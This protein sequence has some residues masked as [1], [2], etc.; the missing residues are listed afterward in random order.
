M[1]KTKTKFNL[2]K[3]LHSL[4]PKRENRGT[5]LV[6]VMALL[7]ALALMGFFF[8]SLAMNNRNDAF[9]FRDASID[10]SDAIEEDVEFIFDTTLR[11]LILGARENE[12][13]SV[14]YGGRNSLV[15]TMLGR[16]MQPFS[17]K[18]INVTWRD[19]SLA[20]VVPVG[21]P[22]VDMLF[23]GFNDADSDLIDDERDAD[24]GNNPEYLQYLQINKSVSAQ[25][26][27]FI[28]SSGA[29][30]RAT[31]PAV[32]SDYDFV[33]A[34]DPDTDITYPDIN[35]IFLAY[36]GIA[37]DG[38][39]VII[40]SFHRPQ[41]N[42][43]FITINDYTDTTTEQYVLRP[44][45]EH[46][47]VASDGTITTTRRFIYDVADATD[48]AVDSGGASGSVATVASGAFP[49][50][51]T[52]VSTV[53]EGVWKNPA[54]DTYLTSAYEY[55]VD[56]D[57]DGVKESIYL[58]LHFPLL[59][60]SN[61]QTYVPMVAMKVVELNSL[62]DLNTHGNHNGDTT[63][64]ANPFGGTSFLSNSNQGMSSSEVNIQWA[65]N[66]R[67]DVTDFAGTLAELDTALEQHRYFYRPAPGYVG[68]PANT[69]EL[70]NMEMFWLLVG[71]ADFNIV[72]P[73]LIENLYEG[74]W[75][76]ETRLEN[77]I[78]TGLA[79]DFPFPGTSAI[80]DNNNQQE[81]ST[82]EHP[83]DL[84]GGGS[85][86]ATG[87]VGKVSFLTLENRLNFQ[88]YSDYLINPT[89]GW[90][91]ADGLH[92]NNLLVPQTTGLQTDE[93]SETHIEPALADV[94]TDDSIFGASELSALHL[95]DSDRATAG[96]TGRLEILAPFNFVSCT[97]AEE[98]RKRFTT[99]SWDL[100][101]FGTFV[102]GSSTTANK[103]REWEYYDH[104]SATTNVFPTVVPAGTDPF[105]PELRE[106][107]SILPVDQSVKRLQR[108]LSIN[109]ILDTN[110]SGSL[111]FR[112][113]TEHPTGLGNSVVATL[114]SPP[115]R[116]EDIGD[117]T[118]Q[119]WLARYD[120]QRMAR[121]IYVLLYMFGGGND[122]IN[123]ASTASPYSAI[124]LKEM[125]QFAVNMVDQLDPD[126]TITVFEYDTNLSN[127]WNVDDNAYLDTGD[128]DRAIV[129]GIEHQQL[130]LNESIAILTDDLGVGNDHASTKWDDDG[131]K[132]FLYLELEN[133]SPYPVT[134]GDGQW[135]I[136]VRPTNALI[137][138]ER[139]LTLLNSFG[140]VG[141]G[142]SSRISLG[143]SGD[144][145]LLTATL[146]SHFN[147]DFDGAT[148]FKQIIPRD[149]D[150]LEGDFD[151]DSDLDV[152]LQMDYSATLYRVHQVHPTA[153][154][155]DNNGNG[156]VDGPEIDNPV[157]PT[158]PPSHDLL[159]ITDPATAIAGAENLT[160]ILRRRA[161]LTRTEP[162]NAPATGTDEAESEDNPWVT[163]DT[164]EIPISAFAI[165]PAATA[166]DIQAAL[167]SMP[168]K[169]RMHPLF[170]SNSELV[171]GTLN[172]VHQAHSIGADNDAAATTVSFW[173]PHYNRDYSSVVELFKIPYYGPD[174]LTAKLA[175]RYTTGTTELRLPVDTATVN[176]ETA[177]R[178]F[179]HPGIPVDPSVVF[180]ST[181]LIDPNTRNRW[182]RVLN[183]LEVPSRHHRHLNVA[184]S[185]IDIGN[186]N[187]ATLGFYRTPGKINLNGLRYPDILAGMLDDTSVI[188]LLFDGANSPVSVD[189]ISE[190]GVRDWWFEF[191]KARDGEDPENI[192]KYYPGLPTSK[193]FRSLSYSQK[194]NYTDTAPDPFDNLDHTIFRRL[195]TDVEDS[196]L[197]TFERRHLFEIG[198]ATDHGGTSGGLPSHVDH[199]SKN[200]LLQKIYNNTTTRSNVF[201]AFIQIDFFEAVEMTDT[202]TGK[203]VVRIGGPLGTPGYR[204]F[205][206]IDRSKAFNL[207]DS[208]DLPDT[209]GA[210]FTF[211]FN[212][213]FDYKSLILHTQQIN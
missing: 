105:R 63:I 74:R 75:G 21:F 38:S 121:D 31:Y 157:V 20:P 139:R 86:T 67:P 200:R 103:F 174:E 70:S 97:R 18:G 191:L 110:V 26:D 132:D 210:T 195:P 138:D 177:G 165:T 115:A 213:N 128:S 76:E 151:P 40:P 58:D 52:G 44:H 206:V 27:D 55:D 15:P 59:E 46:F 54:I 120:R 69:L 154:L 68:N 93:P 189:D 194:I 136:I 73:T 23:D 22:V 201:M 193:P 85:S 79:S 208:T 16:D 144:N 96:N 169:E 199:V 166:V 81:G 158:D 134:I 34:P 84:Y 61:G 64:T 32:S 137:G 182:H 153:T 117:N 183:F 25:S 207:L 60:N 140:S 205:F 175:E 30:E 149:T 181:N 112:P 125:A 51:I 11:Q 89:T 82:F 146:P 142:V 56:A 143:T 102:Y 78:V 24:N 8:Y 41:Y 129:F 179:L 92:A 188:N 94:Q 167:D 184:Q 99:V 62:L 172:G 190:T 162:T 159:A 14:F 163:V 197:L 10:P 111:R 2:N 161:D 147:V 19:K 80:D 7:G 109:G 211:S 100:Q 48:P 145:T 198:T 90:I 141:V 104:S 87:T 37:P 35:N 123:Y 3:T 155:Q 53:K 116:P 42:R 135:Q 29:P 47:A 133:V 185:V 150:A 17:G 98:I 50:L 101:S 66:A 126:N 33:T 186:V 107:I 88:S 171:D 202:G 6:A 173:Q 71:R 124:K 164:M 156:G 180:S 43:H 212:Q 28:Y 152:D 176:S 203:N 122:T 113:L 91:T 83:L 204:R 72:D 131:Y 192:G 65:L 196:S 9:Y 114:G 178:K 209:S 130:A 4:I 45:K 148:T 1:R 5:V 127:G 119:E 39:R 12:K 49:E 57:G 168:S 160:I 106:L 170:G 108:K 77:G 118:D 95:T 36:D 187:G 13:M